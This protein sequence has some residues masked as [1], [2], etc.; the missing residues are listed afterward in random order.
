MRFS[1]GCHCGKV[2][3]EVEI[4]PLEALSCNC[5][6]CAMKGYLHAIVDRDRFK[7]ISGSEELNAYRFGTRAA[8]HLFCRTC[9]IHSFY[10]PRSHPDSVDVN[11]NCLAGDTSG[12]KIT[13]FDGA[14]W[15][16]NVESI[17]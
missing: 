15:E 4:D 14:H 3:Y 10:I 7:L 12:F 6:I 2:R 8:R 9:G 11:V 1:G 13:K 17:R 5:T 16:E